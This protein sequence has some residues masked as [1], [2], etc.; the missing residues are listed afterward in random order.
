MKEIRFK[1]EMGF[2]GTF[3]EENSDKFF[4]EHFLPF[5]IFWASFGGKIKLN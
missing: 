2:I 4:S 3:G 5:L 1:I